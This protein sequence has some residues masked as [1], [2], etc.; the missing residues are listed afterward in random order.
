MNVDILFSKLL[1]T[2]KFHKENT[3]RFKLFD[4]V[5]W[6][7]KN[8]YQCNQSLFS[9]LTEFYSAF[10]SNSILVSKEHTLYQRGINF[11]T[12]LISLVKSIAFLCGFLIK[13]YS[14]LYQQIWYKILFEFLWILNQ[15]H[16]NY[17]LDFLKSK[18]WGN[19]AIKGFIGLSHTERWQNNTNFEHKNI[20]G[21]NISANVFFFVQYTIKSTIKCGLLMIR[22]N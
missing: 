11:S 20:F 4:K 12:I 5:I 7:I 16:D 13:I 19:R 18:T 10:S 8:L 3:Y 17:I 9:S 6:A 2:F 15:N 21:P 22:L 14:F 1:K